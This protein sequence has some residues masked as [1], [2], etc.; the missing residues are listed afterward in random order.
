MY[1]RSISDFLRNISYI[2]QA[3]FNP[4]SRTSQAYHKYISGISWAYL[5]HI[6]CLYPT[7][8]K[9]ILDIS[10]EYL[11]KSIKLIIKFHHSLW[12]P[13]YLQLVQVAACVLVKASA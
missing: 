9:Y 3:S 1:L 2:Y 13:R 10:Q 4:I 12:P 8:L 7:Y 5:R 6:S 11:I